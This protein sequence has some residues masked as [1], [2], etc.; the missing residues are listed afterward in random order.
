MKKSLFIAALLAVSAN[1]LA[2]EVDIYIKQI[3]KECEKQKPFQA[4]CIERTVGQKLTILRYEIAVL[5]NQLSKCKRDKL[6][7]ST[8]KNETKEP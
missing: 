4:A 7:M 6:F 8:E 5:E 3:T 1:A 2:I